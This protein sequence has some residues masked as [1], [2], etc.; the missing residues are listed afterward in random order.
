MKK[1]LFLVPLFFFA[2]VPVIADDVE[3]KAAVQEEAVLSEDEKAAAAEPSEEPSNEE[4][5]ASDSEPGVA[6]RTPKRKTSAA[7]RAS[8]AGSSASEGE[9]A[10]E[11]STVEEAAPAA[12]EEAA[13]SAR[14][15]ATPKKNAAAARIGIMGG[16][17]SFRSASSLA[18]GVVK[19]KAS[20]PKEE[21]KPAE[22]IECARGEFPKGK[23][24]TACD[25]KNNP[26]VRWKN[27]GKDC[28]IE[29][30]SDEYVLIDGDKDQP[31]CLKKCSVWGG[32]ASR[33]WV[34]D[35]V[36][37][38]F[39]GSG[40]FVECAP[41]FFKTLEQ[42][43]SSGV[44]TGHCVLEGTMSGKCSNSGQMKPGKFPNGQCMQVC[45]NGYWSGCT[46]SRF[47]EKGF[48]EANRKDVAYVKDKKD[49]KATVFDCVPN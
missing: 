48:K 40:K 13:N 14:A 25:Q 2:A 44:E 36:E 34:R 45:E 23:T 31:R 19:T 10:A 11:A 9:E 42:T 8:K 20:A 46:I 5:S 32:T 38:S 29:C 49:A 4:V 18:P 39:C 43:G 41:G 33:E 16:G 6:A 37:F 15:A 27:S 26:G 47:C 22:D 24:C 21:E 28:K 1:L 35:I 30:I 3:D 12:V 7:S 17:G